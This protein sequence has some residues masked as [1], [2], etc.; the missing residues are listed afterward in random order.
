VNLTV[1]GAKITAS[2]VPYFV[3]EQSVEI[4]ATIVNP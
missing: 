3:T 4:Q 1:N 2:V